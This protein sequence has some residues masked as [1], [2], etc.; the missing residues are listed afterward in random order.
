MPRSGRIRTGFLFVAVAAFSVVS[1]D[2]SNVRLWIEGPDRL[3]A[4]LDGGPRRGVFS[5][6]LQTTHFRDGPRMGDVESWSIAVAA[7]GARITR[8]ELGPDFTPGSNETELTTGEGNEGAASSIDQ[9][10]VKP[11][12]SDAIRMVVATISVEADRDASDTSFSLSY[13]RSLRT[14][15]GN[16]VENLVRIGGCD[17]SPAIS[18]FE[19]TLPAPISCGR[20]SLG[21]HENDIDSTTL[22]DGTLGVDSPDSLEIRPSLEPGEQGLATAYATLVSNLPT[23]RG[24]GYLQGWT[25]S[26]AVSGDAWPVSASYERSAAWRYWDHGF[27]RTEIIDPERNDSQHGIVSAVVLD[28]T[29]PTAP[30]APRVGTLSVLEFE[31][32]TAPWDGEQP[33][34]VELEFRDG[35]QGEGQ[36]ID[37]YG[38]ANGAPYRVCNIGYGSLQLRLDPRPIPFLRGNANGDSQL[39]ISDPIW[40]LSRLFHREREPS[41][42]AASD[43]NGDGQVDISDGIFLFQ[44]LF[45]GGSAPP[46]PFPNCGV[47]PNVGSEIVCTETSASCD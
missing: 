31:L 2:D 27:R 42:V 19:G 11:P 33:L 24:S 3:Y 23:E 45:L 40:I 17:I 14:T 41:C 36:P 25:I 1:A 8:I 26:L 7:Q 47:H 15:G 18:D 10:A 21:F 30:Q 9:P 46:P 13:V 6:Y 28:F 44:F 35:L 20:F 37:N 43:G 34:E 4:P 22:Y 16:N 12:W 5:C 29:S 39:D 32:Q 38:S